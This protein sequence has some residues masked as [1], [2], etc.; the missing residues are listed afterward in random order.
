MAEWQWR[1]VAGWKPRDLARAQW[2]DVGIVEL[3]PIDLSSYSY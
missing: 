1:S 3:K 2:S